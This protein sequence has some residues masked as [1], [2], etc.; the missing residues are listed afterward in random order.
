MSA[1]FPNWKSMA[2]PDPTSLG[3]GGRTHADT[4]IRIIVHLGT[5]YAVTDAHCN[6]VGA[7]ISNLPEENPNTE[8]FSQLLLLPWLIAN[9]IDSTKLGECARCKRL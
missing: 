1:Y 6:K 8:Q 2:S 4:R 5:V 9:N 3:K 7:L